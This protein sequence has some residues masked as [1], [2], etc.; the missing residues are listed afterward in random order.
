MPGLRGV[1]DLA[2]VLLLVLVASLPD[3]R[4][5]RQPSAAGSDGRRP[6]RNY[7]MEVLADPGPGDAEACSEGFGSLAVAGLAAIPRSRPAFGL[8]RFTRSRKAR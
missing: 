7:L 4:P 1:A 8:G 3:S 5:G 6:Y 2:A